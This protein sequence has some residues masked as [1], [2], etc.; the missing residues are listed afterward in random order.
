MKP[1][2]ARHFPSAALRNS[3][4][5]GRKKEKKAEVVQRKP[6]DM[7]ENPSSGLRPVLTHFTLNKASQQLRSHPEGCGF[8]API[9]ACPLKLSICC[10]SK[11]GFT[12]GASSKEPAHQCRRPKRHRFDPWF[13]KIPWRRACNPLQ[14]SCLK[15]PRHRGAWQAAVHGV[16]QSWISLKRL[17][18]H[19]VNA[20]IK[21]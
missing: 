6:Q 7:S 1:P 2:S 16:E 15:S 18:T 19:P 11:G 14:H 12:G 8:P 21:K 20:S 17:S 3:C 5:Q 9:S 13:R 10:S 4:S